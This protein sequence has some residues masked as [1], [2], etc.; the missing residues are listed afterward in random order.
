MIQNVYR[1]F[2]LF[3]FCFVLSIS[4]IAKSFATQNLKPFKA[5]Y[6]GFKWGDSIGKATMELSP[7]SDNLYSLVYQSSASKFFLSDKR[8]EHSIFSYEEGEFIAMEYHYSRKG[9]GSD[10]KLDV[11]F[12]AET[13]QIE[14]S[15]KKKQWTETWDNETDNQLYRLLLSHALKNK[16]PQIDISFVNYRGDKKQ[17]DIRVLGTETLNVP[18]GQLV[19]TK[20]E[21]LRQN[22]SRKT[23]AWFANDLDFH[24]VRLQQ[25]KDD[26]EQG[27]IQLSTYRVYNP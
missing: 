26:K 7:L 11:M 27:D 3:C 9:T 18:Y 14:L 23:Y 22:S 25:F 6:I 5:E 8:N 19:A 15:N 24:L 1:L 21:I 4:A 20:I 12:N 2:V 17:Y 10:K 16:A 13:K